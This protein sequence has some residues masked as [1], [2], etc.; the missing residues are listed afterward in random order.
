MEA[1]CVCGVS[2]D[3]HQ[4]LEHGYIDRT[5]SGA[6]A[7]LPRDVHF[8]RRELNPATNLYLT[9]EDRLRVQVINSVAGI[10]VDIQ[11]R[12]QLADGQV[13]P[14]RQQLLPGATRALQT[15]E[16]DLCEGF[17]LDLTVST[18]TANTRVGGCFVVCGLIRGTGT[19]AIPS[20]TLISN[21]VNSGNFIGWPEGPSQQSIQ[22]AGLARS[23]QQA[24]PAAGADVVITVPTGA[25]WLIQSLSAQLVTSAAV[26]NRTPHLVVDDGANTLFNSPASAAQAAGV[27]VVYSACGGVQAAFAD[28]AAVLPIPDVS[29]YLQGWRIRTLTTNLQ[30]GDQWQNIWL[31]VIEWLEQ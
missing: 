13:I 16:F 5:Y 15:F 14:M 30:A 12:I 22:G 26:A 20:R 1:I 23:V 25:R 18:P 8:G 4:V 29:S 21:Y 24:N 17:L 7:T 19:N 9:L 28:G 3:K 2:M 31:N 10:E 6:I 11:A 27:T